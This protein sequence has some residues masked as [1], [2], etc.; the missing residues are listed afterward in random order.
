ML[1]LSLLFSI[2]LGNHLFYLAFFFAIKPQKV[3][4]AQNIRYIINIVPHQYL[5]HT[6]LFGVFGFL[7]I[8]FTIILTRT[9]NNEVNELS[10]CI[11]ALVFARFFSFKQKLEMTAANE[12]MKMTEEKTG[13]NK[14]AAH[15]FNVKIFFP[16][17]VV[18]L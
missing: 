10:K 9:N 3:L 8:F 18:F 17:L 15:R 16:P 6:V 13:R 12:E 7:Y 2:N 1:A 4:F 5:Y 14:T 11:I